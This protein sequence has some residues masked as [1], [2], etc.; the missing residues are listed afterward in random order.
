MERVPIDETVLLQRIRDGAPDDFAE[1]I[2]R[3]QSRVFALLSRYERDAHLVEDMAQETFVKAWRALWQFDGRAPFEHWLSRIAVRVAIDHLRARRVHEVRFTD[4]GD[5][6]LEW[7][8][9]PDP[10][11]AP[12]PREAREI[13]E[14]AM[15]K[16]APED[17]LVLTMLE[18]EEYSVKEICARTGWSSVVVRVRAFRARAK[19]RDA[20][21]LLEQHPSP[22]SASKHE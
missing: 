10:K 8:E 16:L 6:A 11:G 21:T 1:I 20:L 2:Q 17:R 3:H 15:R 14:L 22:G 4:L 5:A 18:I 12:E 9:D 19:L 13:L 7:L